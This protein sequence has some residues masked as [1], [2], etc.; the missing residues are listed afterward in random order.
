MGGQATSLN[1]RMIP[2]LGQMRPQQLPTPSC[3]HSGLHLG[4]L[5]EGHGVREKGLAS[6]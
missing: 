4:R 1:V 6:D 5:T 3:T 2:T